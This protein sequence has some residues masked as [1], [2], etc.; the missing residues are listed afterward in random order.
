MRNPKP[1]LHHPSR[2][3]ALPGLR[4]ERWLR[5]A[6]YL[7]VLLLTVSGLAWVGAH[8]FLRPQGA[9]GERVVSPLEPWSMKL[10]G[11]AAML[12]L[13]FVGSILQVHI[14][15]ALRSGRNRVSGWSMIGLLGVLAV[16]GYGLYYVA[17]ETSRPLWSLM[18]WV[19]GGVLAPL[20][21][22]HVLIGRRSRE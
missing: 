12:L 15:R 22:A 9:F 21:V 1:T 4:I 3:R 17:E 7:S 14:R 19:V 2:V 8:Y 10:H 13:F 6:V 11:G 20:L 5:R 18:H 16:S